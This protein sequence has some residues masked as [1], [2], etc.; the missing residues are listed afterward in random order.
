MRLPAKRPKMKKESNFDFQ[1]P[2]GFR[3][4]YF[5]FLPDGNVLEGV[6]A[7]PGNKLSLLHFDG[8]TG[9]VAAQFNCGGVLYQAGFLRHSLL[10]AV[11]F[12]RLSSAVT[13]GRRQKTWNSRQS[14]CPWWYRDLHF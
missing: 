14:R 12:P 6:F 8:K 1:T 5:E 13:K 2:P 3:I 10:G 9:A 4:T 11:T 7:P